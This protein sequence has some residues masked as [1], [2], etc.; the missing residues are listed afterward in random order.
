MAKTIN[1]VNGSGSESLINGLYAVEAN[2]NGYNNVSIDSSSLNVVAGTDTY[3]FTIAATRTINLTDTN[4]QNLPID[5]GTIIL[6][7]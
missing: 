1:I 3:T 6:T 5:S 7:N 2:V 4:Y